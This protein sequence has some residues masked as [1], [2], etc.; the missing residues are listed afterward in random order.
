MNNDEQDYYE[1]VCDEQM[2]RLKEANDAMAAALNAKDATIN[3]QAA[4]LAR[5]QAMFGPLPSQQPPASPQA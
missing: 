3:A 4:D 2:K 5:Y 1:F